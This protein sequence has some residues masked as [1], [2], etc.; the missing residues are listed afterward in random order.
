MLSIEMSDIE[1]R[2]QSNPV[3]FIEEKHLLVQLA[4]NAMKFRARLLKRSDLSRF[5]CHHGL[6]LMKKS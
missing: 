6:M 1:T 3:H 5:C 2:K 4:R